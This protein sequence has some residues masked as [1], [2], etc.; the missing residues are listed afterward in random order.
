MRLLDRRHLVVE[1]RLVEIDAVD[2]QALAARPPP[3]AGCNPCA[4][5][6]PSPMSA[7]TLV[8]I[9]TLSR[10]PLALSQLPMMVSDSPPLMARHPARIAVGGVDGVEAGVDEGVEQRERGLS[11]RRSSR[12]HCRRAPA[13][14]CARSERP[15]RRKS[16]RDVYRKLALILSSAAW[17]GHSSVSPSAL[18]GPSTVRRCACR[19]SASSST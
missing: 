15:S 12:T 17:P 1:M 14:R 10:L 11:R 6:L 18:S 3:R 9:T 16:M 2:L 5:V 4:R 13:A 19:S 7:P 8:A